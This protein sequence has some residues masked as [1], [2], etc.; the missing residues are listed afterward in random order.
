MKYAMNDM[1]A[2]YTHYNPATGKNEPTENKL[3]EKED[4]DKE[5]SKDDKADV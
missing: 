4:K 1:N 2:V 5:D 3:P